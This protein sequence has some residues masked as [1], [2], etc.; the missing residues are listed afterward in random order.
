MSSC[1]VLRTLTHL[2]LS[3]YATA[4]SIKQKSQKLM[5][6][7]YELNDKWVKVLRIEQ[8]LEDGP[9]EKISPT[10]ED[11]CSQSLTRRL[12]TACC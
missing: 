1:S 6:E 7:Q 12:M 4:K 10:R 3:S 11:A 5:S 8:E 9:Q 2:S